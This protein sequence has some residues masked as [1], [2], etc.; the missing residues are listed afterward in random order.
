[1]L[2]ITKTLTLVLAL[3]AAAPAL[4]Q[5]APAPA[6]ADGTATET[7]AAPAAPAD[8]TQADPTLSMGVDA[9]APQDGPG[10]M[11]VKAT[12]DDWELRCIRAQDGSDPCQLYQLL[13]DEQATPVAEVSMLTL[14][15]G[16]QAAAGATIITPLETLLPDGLTLAV[17]GGQNK[18]YPFTFCTAIGCVARV[19]FTA[20]EVAN[21][22]KGSKATLTIV[23]VGAPDKKVTLNLSLKGFT[24]GYD[25][26]VAEA[27]KP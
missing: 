5:T 26:L 4:A 19:G 17:D 2:D 15:K 3:G 12:Y 10:S 8:A 22:K 9:N 20:D 11:Y 18:R 27:P 23:P 1:M 24:A 14:P 16:A 7:P 13:K 6:P 21:F 25:A